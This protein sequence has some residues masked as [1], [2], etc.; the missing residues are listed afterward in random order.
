MRLVLFDIFSILISENRFILQDA[1]LRISVPTP[2]YG[3]NVDSWDLP[4]KCGPRLRAKRRFL[5]FARK[6]QLPVTG[7]TLILGICP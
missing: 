3:Q 6:M 7:K 1:V 5:K 4:V 2:G